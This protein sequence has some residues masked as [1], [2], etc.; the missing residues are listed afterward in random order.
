MLVFATC[1]SQWHSFGS[2]TS[3]HMKSIDSE[4]PYVRTRHLGE[5]LSSK[6]ERPPSTTNMWMLEE[7]EKKDYL[8][9][10]QAKAYAGASTIHGLTYIAED[11]RPN[12]E[13]YTL[14]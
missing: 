1:T 3:R 14:V 9:K 6:P 5:D 12:T 2:K 13:R 11:G 4:L 7:N 8:L 10:R